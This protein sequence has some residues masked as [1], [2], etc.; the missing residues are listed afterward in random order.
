MAETL[1]VLSLVSARR[2][3]RQRAAMS[4]SLSRNAN[5]EAH[6]ACG[7]RSSRTS[8][9][10]APLHVAFVFEKNCKARMRLTSQ[11]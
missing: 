5:V 4:A 9:G 7:Y 8:G 6:Q 10:Y 11:R 3:D 2:H 1:S